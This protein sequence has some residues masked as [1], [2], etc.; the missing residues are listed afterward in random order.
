M[1]LKETAE[2]MNLTPQTVRNLLR[3]GRLTGTKDSKS[4]WCVTKEAV[5]DYLATK[6]VRKCTKAYIIRLHPE[7]DL[8][9]F[10]YL[11]GRGIT[12]EK[13]YKTKS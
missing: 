4:K 10:N 12:I 6:G 3:K 5:A 7:R 1:N 11:E 13:R 9:V 8:D 2:Y